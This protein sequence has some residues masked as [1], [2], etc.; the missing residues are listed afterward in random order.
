MRH[1]AGLVLLFG[2]ALGASGADWIPGTNGWSVSSGTTPHYYIQPDNVF[3]VEQAHPRLFLK[4]GDLQWFRNRRTSA[5]PVGDR[6]NALKGNA[7][8]ITRDFPDP[9]GVNDILDS[10]DARRGMST[11]FVGML[12]TNSAYIQWSIGWAKAMAARTMPPQE[13]AVDA[14]F[15]GR[16]FYM[17]IIYDWLY[18]HISTADRATIRDS[19]IAY[20]TVLKNCEAMQNPM[21]TAGHERG[22]GYP[23]L[24]AGALAVYGDYAG[25]S[26]IIALCRKHITGGIYQTQAWI[27]ADG[28]YHMGYGYTSACTGYDLYLLWTS[29][30]TDVVLDNWIGGLANW[31]T[32]GLLKAGQLQEGSDTFTTDA[33]LGVFSA[34][35]AAG[36]QKSR[37]AMWYLDNNGIECKYGHSFIQFL[38]LDPAVT[39]QAP[40]GLPRERLYDR[41]GFSVA[42][43][44]WNLDGTAT[45]FGFKS[46]P[47]YS[48][49][50]HHRDENSFTLYYKGHLAVDSGFY[51]WYNSQHWRNYYMRTVAHNG[52]VVYNQGQN[53]TIWGAPISNDGG[54]IFKIGETISNDGLETRDWTSDPRRLSEIQPG[55]WASL[56][57]ITKYEAGDEYVYAVGDATKAYDPAWVTLAQRETVYLRA[58]NRAHPVIVIMDRVGSTRTD[59]E[60]RFLLHTVNQPV[61]S[62]MIAVNENNGGRLS[63]MTVYPANAIIR[64]IGGSGNEFAVNGTNYPLDSVPW[65]EFTPGA[66]R[67]EVAAPAGSLTN[68]FLHVLFVD[69]AGAAAVTTNAAAL[70]SGADYLGVRLSGYVMVFPKSPGGFTSLN[71]SLPAGVAGRQL[72]FGLPPGTNVVIASNGIYQR[73]VTAGSGGCAVFDAGA[74][75]ATSISVTVCPPLDRYGIPTAW[76]LRNFGTTNG[77]LTGA[78]EDWDGDG[79]CNMAE[80]VAGTAP[81]NAAAV[82]KIQSAG[83]QAGTF[84][85]SFGTVTGRTY[86]L[87]YCDDLFSGV[88]AVVTGNVAG[89]GGQLQIKDTN[90]PVRRFYRVGVDLM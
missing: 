43:D 59:S 41:V 54:Q 26:D 53:M 7:S 64:S 2:A 13:E 88:W 90:H 61:S 71:Y 69:D 85:L 27:A 9:A 42:K 15:C 28:G 33:A 25:V 10:W 49:N 56:D 51:D 4:P 86:S 29:G 23:A 20:M 1:I 39:A 6:W 66:W 18:P 78:M 24:T 8:D 5:N 16:L 60:K 74:G 31:Y 87:K 48:L 19:I 11:A 35:Y 82:L 45:H 63:T 57:G 37:Q 36:I 38:L 62:G 76:E 58:T 84:G 72:V 73:S 17:A 83:Y 12:E 89:T 81:T 52:V 44:N 14:V 65:S 46:S 47:F 21:Y 55:G 30:T 3:R 70:I 79:A 77:P 34:A 75:G 68:Q 40:S 80:Y 22:Y 50:H 32:Y 67:L